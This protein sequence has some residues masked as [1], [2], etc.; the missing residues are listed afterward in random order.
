MSNKTMLLMMMTKGMVESAWTEDMG[1]FLHLQ[2]PDK[3]KI[4]RSLEK[5][6]LKIINKLHSMQQFVIKASFIKDDG[7]QFVYY[8]YYIYII[9]IMSRRQLG[10]P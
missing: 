9:I 7:I 3:R 5:L 1:Q 8:I 6:Q 10:Y 2:D 4:L